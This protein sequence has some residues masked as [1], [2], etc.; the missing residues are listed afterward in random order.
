MQDAMLGPSGRQSCGCGIIPDVMT[1]LAQI[2]DTIEEDAP[3]ATE[4]LL[5]LAH[6][7]LRELGN[8]KRTQGGRQNAE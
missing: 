8:P 4:Q 6:D 3:S 7:E 1:D 2:L 5:P